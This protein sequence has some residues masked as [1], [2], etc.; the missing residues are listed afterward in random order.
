M[1]SPVATLT[2]WSVSLTS[3]SHRARD[4]GAIWAS[5]LVIYILKHAFVMIP[6]VCLLETVLLARVNN[7]VLVF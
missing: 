4:R 3:A 2:L 6:S 7:D 5:R 1:L